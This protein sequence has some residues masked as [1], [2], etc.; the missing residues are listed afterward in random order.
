[1]PITE[2]NVG[3]VVVCSARL[4]CMAVP[5]SK[6]RQGNLYQS[7]SEQLFGSCCLIDLLM[8][9][10]DQLYSSF[11]DHYLESINLNTGPFRVF[12]K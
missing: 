12:L 3:E 6:T 1:M 11:S 9:F 7:A 2:E 4:P 8:I 5:L 10:V